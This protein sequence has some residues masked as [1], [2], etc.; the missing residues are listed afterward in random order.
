M[1]AAIRKLE[2]FS[3]KLRPRQKVTDRAL[4]EAYRRLGN[5]HLVGKELGIDGS[6][7]HEALRRLGEA[8][9]V[10]V[11]TREEDRR[12]KAEYHIAADA[13]QLQR[14][15][16]SMGRSKTTIC[17]R[18]GKLG[19]TNT[20]RDKRWNGTWKYIDEEYA[21]GL[22]DAFK[23][24]SL[25]LIHYC[26]DK[27]YPQTGFSEC[28]RRF[29]ADEWDHVIELKAPQQSRYRHGR[30][31]E[32]QVRDHLRKVGFF[33]LRSP[34]SKSP[35]DLIAVRP[36]EVLLVQCKRH[37]ELGIKG[38]NDLF[39]LAKSCGATPILASKPHFRGVLYEKLIDRKDGSKRAQ[40]KIIVTIT[41]IT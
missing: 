3:T 30:Q 11:F 26:S 38:W 1:S 21:K 19:L 7:A 35:I 37:G 29:F 25:G 15:A 33:A 17:I 23:K 32:Y 34:A 5:V 14:L 24:S 13:G 10:N 40:P 36:N 2:T 41:E 6:S 18:A 20:K 22:F 31:F 39:D 4:V 28:M 27:G 12:L 9:P 8:K 16:Q